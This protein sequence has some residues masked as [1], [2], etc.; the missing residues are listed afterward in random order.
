MKT[1]VRKSEGGVCRRGVEMY[2]GQLGEKG[3]GNGV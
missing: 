2:V 3:V 1:G